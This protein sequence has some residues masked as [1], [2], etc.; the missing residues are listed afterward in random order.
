MNDNIPRLLLFNLLDFF[1]L[2]FVWF[3]IRCPWS[4][5][6]VTVVRSFSWS[7]VRSVVRSKCYSSVHH[8]TH[9]HW[10]YHTPGIPTKP[11]QKKQITGRPTIKNR[12]RFHFRILSPSLILWVTE[13]EGLV[14]SVTLSKFPFCCF[15]LCLR[16]S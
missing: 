4:T 12:Q 15:L 6:L 8:T 11:I 10:L 13:L 5:T 16:L 14:P 3:G 1:I 9:A 2:C 7:V